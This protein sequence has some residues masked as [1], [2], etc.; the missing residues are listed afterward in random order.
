MAISA[1][2]VISRPPVLIDGNKRKTINDVT[3]DSSYS[4]TPGEALTA[5]QLG[6]RRVD[7]ATCE[8]AGTSTNAGG[9]STGQIS[10]AKYDATNAALIVYKGDG[11]VA[12]TTNL[13]DLVVRVQ[14]WGY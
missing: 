7:Y 3:F 8:V 13:S 10:G 12:S 2:S 9:N 6:L 4:A 5:A 1:S 14:A 11:E